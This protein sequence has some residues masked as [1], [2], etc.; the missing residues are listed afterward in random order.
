M[1]PG[2]RP[3]SIP[4]TATTTAWSLTNLKAA[5]LG[6]P[7]SSGAGEPPLSIDRRLLSMA[8]LLN[9]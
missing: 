4:S 9:R 6:V 3:G 2:D 7:S 1:R 5:L 8:R